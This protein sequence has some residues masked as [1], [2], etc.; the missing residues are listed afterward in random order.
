MPQLLTIIIALILQ[1]ILDIPA[2]GQYVGIGFTVLGV[3]MIVLG[4]WLTMAHKWRG[5]TMPED[6]KLSKKEK[7]LSLH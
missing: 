5:D 1:F 2:I 3:L 6:T 4:I 7:K